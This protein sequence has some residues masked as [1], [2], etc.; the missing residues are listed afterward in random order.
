VPG[1]SEVFLGAIVAYANE[2]KQ[3]LLGVASETL[4]R[5]GAVSA[6]CALEMARGARRALAADVALSVTGIAG[7]DGSSADK[8]VGLVFLCATG[9]TETLGQ[10]IRFS[11]D[12]D[13]IRR[14]ATVAALHLTRRLLESSDF[15]SKTLALSGRR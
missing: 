5:Y 12:R 7:P 15:E 10:E 13:Q 8:P 9:E 6:E 3:T 2:I 14:Y 1:A 4:G 11:G